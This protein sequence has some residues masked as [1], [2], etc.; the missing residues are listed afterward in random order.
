MDEILPIEEIEKQFDSEWVLIADPQH[1]EFTQLRAGR[2]IFHSPDR[3]EVYQKAVELRLP[4]IA[5][6]YFGPRPE[7]VVLG[8]RPYVGRN[9]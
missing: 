6:R 8:L 9:R 2:V 4:H 7:H 3:D 5:V 1:D